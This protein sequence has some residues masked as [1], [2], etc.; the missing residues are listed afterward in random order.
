MQNVANIYCSITL[1]T[2]VFRFDFK[3]NLRKD[4]GFGT[5]TQKAKTYV[6][7]KYKQEAEMILKIPK[8]K[9]MNKFAGQ[10]KL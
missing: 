7:F 3:R 5:K 9:L 6:T 10:K 2:V 8:T 4:R 1:F